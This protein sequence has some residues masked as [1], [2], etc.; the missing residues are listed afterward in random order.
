VKH[1]YLP[2]LISVAAPVLSGCVGTTGGELVTFDAFA[3]GPEDAFAGEPYTFENS[4]G[5]A[6]TLT[7]ATVHVGALYLNQSRP[8]S[9]SSD[10]RCFLSGV[11]GAEVTSGLDIDLL[12]GD[13]QPF[14]QP[15]SGTTT[16]VQT[17]EV[18]LFGGGDINEPT[19][20]TALLDVAGTA[21]K[22]GTDYPFEGRITISDNRVIAPSSP[23]QPGSHPICKQRIVTPIRADLALAPG[24]SL[25]LRVDPHGLFANVE[26]SALEQVEAEPPLYRFRDDAGDAPS[27]NLYTG[28]R[29]ASGT[30]SFQTRTGE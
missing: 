2:L 17:G 15:G 22:G 19:D 13:L 10:T 27:R 9:V 26:F 30:Y 20:P 25:V 5:Y 29:A 12:S 18:W 4:R 7:R 24:D 8:A 28:L 21:S 14:P 6:V 11:Y 1:H 23:A 3:A 16:P